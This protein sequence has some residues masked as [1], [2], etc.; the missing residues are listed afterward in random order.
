MRIGL[1]VGLAGTVLG[2]TIAQAQPG[3]PT[4]TASAPPA[5]PAP[6]APAAPATPP[7]PA[8]LASPTVAVPS[9]RVFFADTAAITPTGQTSVSWRL[10]ELQLRHAI[11]PRV[12][13]A[14][15]GLVTPGAHG[16][17]GLYAQGKA[18]VVQTERIA[19]AVLVGGGVSPRESHKSF[20]VG[21]ALASLCVDGPGCVVL[22]NLTAHA[23][24]QAG[25]TAPLV[26][27]GGVVI[28]GRGAVVA[29]YQHAPDLP[30]TWSWSAPATGIYVGAR[31]RG[32]RLQVDLGVGAFVPEDNCPDGDP[33]CDTAEGL[34]L[35]LLA[36]SG[37]L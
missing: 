3:P 21:A 16:A 5:P 33:L 31:Y 20:A 7:A 18:A 32:P 15:S 29:E 22:V 19:I 28:G 34:T 9:G 12:E 10:I 27:G 30:A 2:S 11:H 4:A 26:Y 6:A 35:P 37:S 8:G 25:A 24:R 36:V 17:A 1:V 23:V 14:A 13:L